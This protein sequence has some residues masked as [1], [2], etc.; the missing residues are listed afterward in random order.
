[1]K[2]LLPLHTNV[3]YSLQENDKKE[4]ETAGEEILCEI[5]FIENSY[6]AR[7]SDLKKRIENDYVLNKYK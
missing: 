6:K 3:F 2:I 4:A 1:M 5:I 7:F